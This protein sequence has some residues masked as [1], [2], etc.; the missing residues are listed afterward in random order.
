ML[1]GLSER[2]RS[3]MRDRE[4]E[5]ARERERESKRARNVKPCFGPFY[6]SLVINLQTVTLTHAPAPTPTH[7][8]THKPEHI[9][10]HMCIE[11]LCVG[12]YEQTHA[13]TYTQAHTHLYQSTAIAT[14]VF[15]MKPFPDNPFY[16]IIPSSGIS[17]LI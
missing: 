12:E 17:P 6:G 14:P 8:H 11:L 16:L 2:E 3:R 4:R 10:K 9:Q 7:T 13:H 5:R 15:H 1:E